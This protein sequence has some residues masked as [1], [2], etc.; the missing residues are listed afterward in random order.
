MAADI[1]TAREAAH[2]SKKD[3][4]HRRADT[5][6]AA[7]GVSYGGGQP[8]GLFSCFASEVLTDIGVIRFQVYL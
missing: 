5:P 2:F 8:V 6:A 1:D 7:V 4:K 3:L